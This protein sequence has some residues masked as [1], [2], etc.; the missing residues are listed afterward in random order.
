[1]AKILAIDDEEETLIFVANVLGKEHDVVTVESWVTA[2][3][4]IVRDKF[5]LILLDIMLPGLSG[6]KLVE[7]LKKRITDKPLNIVL[8]S[9]IDERELQQ[10]TKESGAK[11]YIHKSYAPGLLPLRVQRFLR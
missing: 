1:M 10:K 2:M 6:D 11:G 4:Y 9:G 7:I 5:D 8:F 3:E